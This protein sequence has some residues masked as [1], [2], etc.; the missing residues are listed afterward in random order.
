MKV[1]VVWGCVQVVAIVFGARK[2]VP[3]LASLCSI[4]LPLLGAARRA[5][6][7]S[8]PRRLGGF[9]AGT[10]KAGLCE[11]SGLGSLDTFRVSH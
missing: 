9:S 1:L 7:A 8:S 4:A 11:D 5:N 2:K 6:F 10:G 3:A